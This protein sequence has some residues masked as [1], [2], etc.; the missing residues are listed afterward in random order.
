M[1]VSFFSY[2]VQKAFSYCSL[3]IYR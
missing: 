1:I 2:K 3:C